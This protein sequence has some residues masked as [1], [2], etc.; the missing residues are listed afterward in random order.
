MPRSENYIRRERGAT[1]VEYSIIIALVALVAFVAVKK[2]GNQTKVDNLL[3]ACQLDCY[4]YCVGSGYWQ[5]D[6]CLQPG[7]CN[8]GGLCTYA[9]GKV[10]RDTT[11]LQGG[12]VG[13]CVT[14]GSCNFLPPNWRP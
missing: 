10:G 8:D 11:T 2:V 4:G 9:Y 5:P 3:V 7:W 12:S 1:L 6:W 13:N 14:P